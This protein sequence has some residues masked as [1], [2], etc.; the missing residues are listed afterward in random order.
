MQDKTSD[1]AFL[2]ALHNDHHHRRP[3]WY[4]SCLTNPT[5]PSWWRIYIGQAMDINAI[6][7][8]HRRNATNPNQNALLCHNW[9]NNLPI[10]ENKQLSSVAT[11]VCLGFDKTGMKGD[12]ALLF[13]S[14]VGMF[15]S[16]IFRTLQSR[17]LQQWHPHP[18][19]SEVRGLNV[20]LPI[21]QSFLT[22][23]RGFSQ[24]FKSE[25]PETREYAHN[26]SRASQSQCEDCR[27]WVQAPDSTMS[28]RGYR[29]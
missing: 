24:L 13:L 19:Q 28:C 20:A 22:G 29:L 15:F 1:Y 9:R 2:S 21:L 10:P 8:Q 7:A 16:L 11:I 17:D 5:K 18:F 25:D 3:G 6:G 4:L 27:S 23:L 26:M 12:E 14:I